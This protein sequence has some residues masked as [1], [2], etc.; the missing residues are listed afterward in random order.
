MH[1]RTVDKYLAQE[2]LRTHVEREKPKLTTERRAA[3]YKFA[4]E[5]LHW[6]I[7]DWKNV[8]FSDESVISR[9]GSYGKKFYR[10]RPG[11]MR[12][13]SNPTKRTMQAGGGK[14]MV[15]GCMTYNGL[16]DLCWL[17][18]GLDSQ[19]YVE[20]LQ[21]YVI[22]SQDYRRLDRGKFIFQQ[23]NAKVHTAKIVK[24]YFLKSKIRIM[25]WPS[26]SPD[27]N[28]IE[29]VWG[30][31]KRHLDQYDSDPESMKELWERVQ[32]VWNKIPEDFIHHLY[33]SMPT[34]MS[35]VCKHQGDHIDY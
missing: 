12:P 29:L 1:A 11:N 25:N 28:P 33:E 15:W 16:G 22:A 6:T 13:E 18:Q 32:D 34:R 9:I 24:G 4:Q 30:Y 17:P 27:L 14:I 10:K 20:V 8:M 5:H 3:R 23:D 2:G 21:D 31:P 26:N 7:D 35:M 19:L